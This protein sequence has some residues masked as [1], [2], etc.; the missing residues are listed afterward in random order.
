MSKI[1]GS[2]RVWASFLAICFVLL[3]FYLPVLS[4]KLDQAAITSALTAFVLFIVAETVAGAGKGWAIFKQFKFWALL[5]SLAFIF[6][7]AFVPGFP[8]SED[9]IQIFIAAIG[10]TSVSLAYRP[11]GTTKA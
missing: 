11:I 4:D 10:S 1:L 9:L 7:R 6:I 2:S 3:A 5:T 8:V